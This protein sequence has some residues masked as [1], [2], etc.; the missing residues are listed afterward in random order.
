MCNATD[1]AALWNVTEL[2]RL[3]YRPSM[4]LGGSTALLFA[5]PE[6]LARADNL[7]ETLSR[8]CRITASNPVR[9]SWRTHQACRSDPM[10]SFACYGRSETIR[11]TKVGA[12]LAPLGPCSNPRSRKLSRTRRS[13]S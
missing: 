11:I 5:A 8:R 3:R 4:E 1:W 9:R 12:M 10:S 2:P 6:V 13:S 7:V